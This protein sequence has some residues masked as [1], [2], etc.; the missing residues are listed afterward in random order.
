MKY[1]LNTSK[2]Q[3]KISKK[4]INEICELLEDESNEI[5]E[6]I[7]AYN[8]PVSTEEI[9]EMN[10][11]IYIKRCCEHCGKQMIRPIRNHKEGVLYFCR[12]CGHV[13][14]EDGYVCQCSNCKKIR[15]RELIKS[16]P[17]ISDWELEEYKPEALPLVLNMKLFKQLYKYGQMDLNI[18]VDGQ[19][20]KFFLLQY[21][22]QEEEK[23]TV[24][25]LK[26][27][28][29]LGLLFVN[30]ELTP[31]WA[32]DFNS[33]IT[34]IDINLYYGKMVFFVWM[35][36]EKYKK[37][38]NRKFFFTLDNIVEMR[39]KLI[40]EISMAAL[41]YV[42]EQASRRSYDLIIK[43][44]DEKMIKEFIGNFSYGIFTGMTL[45]VLRRKS[46]ELNEGKITKANIANDTI[47]T[48]YNFQLHAITENYM[49][50]IGT[51]DCSD[52]LLEFL[53]IYLGMDNSCLS[54]TVDEIIMES[55]Y[56]SVDKEVLNAI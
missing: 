34:N 30:K 23:L 42:I 44:S 10:P 26:E 45:A 35:T 28:Y 24:D 8:L 6:V 49:Q 17:D 37:F 3:L 50:K 53:E 15:K 19:L 48:I 5:I 25:E 51:L 21:N 56:D 13:V 11:G 47:K 54:K 16:L 14:V 1:Y 4:E 31:E 52:R 27:L 41:H 40:E 38:I 29:S 55:F 7:K 43:R 18:K 12:N 46:D 9:L 33:T 2:K 20:V 39:D 32:Y 22:L 36:K